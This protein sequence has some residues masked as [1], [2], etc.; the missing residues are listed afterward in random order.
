MNYDHM[1]DRELIQ[2]TRGETGIIRALAERLEL[3]HERASVFGEIRLLMETLG[4][5]TYKDNPRQ[6]MRYMNSLDDDKDW[7]TA[8]TTAIHIANTIGYALS[9]GFDMDEAWTKLMKET[10]DAALDQESPQLKLF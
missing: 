4:D 9:R 5:T 7:S 2:H 10:M 1:T 3:M 6:A 8:N